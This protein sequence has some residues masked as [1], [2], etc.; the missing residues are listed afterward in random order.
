PQDNPFVGQAGAQP[1]IWSYGHRNIQSAVITEAGVLWTV[2][3][4]PRGGD[5]LNNPQPGV[6]HGWPV[7]T[8]GVNYNGTEVGQGITQLEGMAQPNYYW[9]PVIAPSG[10]AEYTDDLIDE[11]DGALLVGGLVSQGIVIL[12]MDGGRVERE[13]RVSLGH[14]IRD[15]RVGPDGAVYAV[16]TSRRSGSRIIRI[17]PAEAS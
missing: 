7:I 14:R 5:E 4:G 9:D 16:T 11:W 1:A 15:V 2:E 3:H 6:N 10:M 17:A 8:Y 12:H 13:D